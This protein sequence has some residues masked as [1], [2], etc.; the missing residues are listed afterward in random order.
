MDLVLSIVRCPD[1]A[2]PETRSFGGG[3]VVLGRGEDCT[4]KLVDPDQH[5]S[6]RHCAVSFHGGAWH[7]TDLSTNGT[8][9]NRAAAPIGKGNE[10]ALNDGDRLTLGEYEIE[11]R[12]AAPARGAMFP[13]QAAPADDP[14]AAFTTEPPA[15]PGPVPLGGPLIPD[16]FS[17]EPEPPQED[18]WHGGSR[19][20]H[21]PAGSDYFAPPKVTPAPLPDDWDLGPLPSTPTAAPGGKIPD[22][23]DLDAPPPPPAQ[24][25]AEPPREAAPLPPPAPVASPV[26]AAGPTPPAAAGD[27]A[28][29]EA[30]LEGMGLA[31]IEPGGP[32][33][34]TLMKGLGAAFRAFVEGLREV[35]ITRATIKSEFRIEQTII[36]ARGNNPLKFSPTAEDALVA[37]LGRSRAFMAPDAAVKD[38]LDD[39]KRHELATMEAMQAAVRAL[40]A[41]LDPAAIRSEAEQ[42]GG[43]SLLPAQ[44]RA[45]AFEIFEQRFAAALADLDDSSDGVF[46]RAFAKAYEAASGKR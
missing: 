18:P 32:D 31:G 28:L 7:V 22:E 16:D 26:R 17:L 14:F 36:A 45:R 9:V 10:V 11:V 20:D 42:G 43:L 23:W 21:M 12:I 40:L 46:A 29:L 34:A 2:V 19:P 6:R 15:G 5:L 44:K 13:P 41:R 33:P 1:A 25:P 24:P 39:I 3:E 27:A 37:M 30:F 35:L 4:W 38:A 8:F